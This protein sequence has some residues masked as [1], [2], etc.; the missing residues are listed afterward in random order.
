MATRTSSEV[1]R[2]GRRAELLEIAARLFADGGY[3]GTSMGDIGAAAGISGPALYWH[4]SS[5]EA[6]LSELLADVSEDLLSGAR[7]C[8]A[9]ATDGAQALAL[10]VDAHLAFAV[11]EVAMITLHE[12]ELVHLPPDTQHRIRRAQRLYIEEWVAALRQVHPASSA[13]RC[14]AVV[15]GTFGLLNSTPRLTWMSASELT[16]VLRQAALATLG[17]V[18]P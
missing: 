7:A 1:G 16:R 13:E 9:E 4:F 18:Q 11:G 5:K 15:Q 8:R 12:R 17:S 14:R 10:L 2:G 3:A 6:L